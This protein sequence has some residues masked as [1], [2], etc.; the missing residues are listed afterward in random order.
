MEEP[1]K[2]SKDS[3]VI[4][5]RLV[6]VIHLPEDADGMT[7]IISYEFTEHNNIMHVFYAS[8]YCVAPTL[9]RNHMPEGYLR[10][11][12][13]REIEGMEEN[14]IFELSAIEII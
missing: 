7:C 11:Q 8:V 3:T 4:R 2:Y 9:L 13:L 1:L 6:G 5:R 14:V 12:V 10:E